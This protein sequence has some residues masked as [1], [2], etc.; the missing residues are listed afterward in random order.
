[1]TGHPMQRREFL[2]GLGAATAWPVAAGAQQPVPIVG[3]LGARERSE[4]DITAFRQGLSRSGYIEGQNVAVEYRWAEGKYDRLPAL[5]IDLVSRR[6]SVIFA[7][8]NPSVQVAKAA[9]ATIPIV[10]V[11]GADPVSLGLVA[12]LNRPGGNITGVSF[13]STAVVAKMLELLHD[14]VPKASVIAA[15]VNPANPNGETDARE[16]TEAARVLGVKLQVLKASNDRELDAALAGLV[17]T[18]AQAVLVAGDGFL[19]DEKHRILGVTTPQSI[20]VIARGELFAQAGGLMGYGSDI[21]E[22][23]RHAAVYVGRILKGEKPAD[24]PVQQSTKVE[25]II[26]MKTAKALGLTF[27]LTILGRADRVIE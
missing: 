22:A 10:F 5:T 14:A 23:I 13:L 6:V 26:N 18:R 11:I 27:P 3:Y 24:L 25:L 2:G 7:V 20:P 16:A 15:L 21:Y 9:S 8:D 1:M 19:A 4:A 12:S 17:E